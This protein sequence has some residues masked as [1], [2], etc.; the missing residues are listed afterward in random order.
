MFR[1]HFLSEGRAAARQAS[2]RSKADRATETVVAAVLM[3]PPD[4]RHDAPVA[5][6]LVVGS[7]HGRLMALEVDLGTETLTKIWQREVE[8]QVAVSALSAVGNRSVAAL[9]D[10]AGL[11]DVVDVDFPFAE[12]RGLALRSHSGPVTGLLWTPDAALV[13]VGKDQRLLVR[14]GETATAVVDLRAS[15]HQR[16]SAAPLLGATRDGQREDGARR[17]GASSDRSQQPAS[18]PRTSDYERLFGSAS[19]VWLGQGLLV[20][21]DNHGCLTVLDVAGGG[22]TSAAHSIG[23]GDWAPIR[24]L[25]ASRDRSLLV[26]VDSRGASGFVP[27]D[28]SETGTGGRVTFE[29][30]AVLLCCPWRTD[31]GATGYGGGAGS[32]AAGCACVWRLAGPEELAVV[33]S[34][35]SRLSFF[36]FSD[37]SPS[38]GR[39]P[40]AVATL[41]FGAPVSALGI[42]PSGSLLAVAYTAMMMPATPAID[43]I[44]VGADQPV[45]VARL[46]APGTGPVASITWGPEGLLAAVVHRGGGLVS[47]LMLD[48]DRVGLQA[49]TDLCRGTDDHPLPTVVVFGSHDGVMIAGF[50]NGVVSAYTF[51]GTN[52]L[53]AARAAVPPVGDG[54]SWIVFLESM[55][56]TSV[57]G[58][59]RHAPTLRPTLVREGEGASGLPVTNGG[60]FSVGRVRRRRQW[61]PWDSLPPSKAAP[62]DDGRRWGSLTPFAA[63]PPEGDRFVGG[64]DDRSVSDSL[65]SE[66]AGGAWMS[67]IGPERSDGGGAARSQAGETGWSDVMFSAARTSTTDGAW[68]RSPDRVGDPRLP[69][70]GGGESVVEW[71]GTQD[72]AGQVT[73]PTRM[74]TMSRPPSMTFQVPVD[75]VYEQ[76]PLP[77]PRSPPLPSPPLSPRDSSARHEVRPRSPPLPSPP[78]SPRSRHPDR[79]RDRQ[80]PPRPLLS[81]HSLPP[82]ALAGSARRQEAVYERRPDKAGG[83]FLGPRQVSWP[84]YRQMPPDDRRPMDSLYQGPPSQTFYRS[85]SGGSGGSGGGG[86]G[87]GGG[88]FRPWEP[89]RPPP[90]DLG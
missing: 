19:P 75:V 79:S 15:L 47:T 24:C 46:E 85:H 81:G 44:V 11:L 17:R 4:T 9:Q 78:L 90:P 1:V 10:L 64:T 42:H 20:C 68:S 62:A 74:A 22:G 84:H 2:S 7:S 52:R 6:V 53:E 41:D 29:S 77:R 37:R 45:V 56:A 83:G 65:A 49:P 31:G 8:P 28:W 89:Q 57:T 30:A 66:S 51:D 63:A 88:T 16:L 80:V 71:W 48:A 58:P 67:G 73:R 25:A 38:L 3:A 32:L 27:L 33:P 21:G 55:A 13:S 61:R 50:E 82:I 70:P 59:G 36:S 23:L 26:F 54:D 34:G 39:E 60:R 76:R 40:Y 14:R 18:T 35:E 87:G 43:L 5:P 12:A 86:G 69:G 72:Q